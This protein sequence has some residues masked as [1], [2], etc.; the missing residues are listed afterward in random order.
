[1]RLSRT[2]TDTNRAELMAALKG[3]PVG[4][5]FELVDDPRTLKQN[6]LMWA[7]LNEVSAQ[8]PWGDPPE[9]YEPEDWKCAFMKAA[10]HKLRFMPAVDG[11]G[12]VALG[13]RS[14]RLGKEEFADL[15]ETIYSQGLQRGVVFPG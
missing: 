15:I 8:L 9:T 5:T 2:I 14:S 13:Y 7:L 6:R 3:A 10:G 4:S 12:V 1:M 11:N